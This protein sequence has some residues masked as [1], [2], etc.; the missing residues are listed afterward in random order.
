MDAL[1]AFVFFMFVAVLLVGGAQK[2]SLSYPIALILGGGVLGMI[3]GLAPVDIDPTILLV[4]VLPPIL[5]YAAYSIAFKEFIH[6]LKD[7]FYLAIVLVGI[8]TL[9]AG[10]LF[11]WLFPELPWSLAFTFGAIVSPP[12]AVAATAI[13]KRFAI[14]SRLK[15]ILEGESLINDASGL[16]IY[17]FAVVALM[18]GHFSLKEASFHAFY[19]GIVGITIGLI[20]G[21]LF[22]KLAAYLNPVLAVVN[23]FIIPY[24]TYCLADFLNASGVLA[25]VSCGLLGSRMLI[26]QLSP[27]TRVLAWAAWDIL[28][29]L[30]NC[31]IFIL[32]GLDFGQIVQKMPL[33]QILLFSG[34]GI[35]ITLAIILVRF[36]CIYAR[37]GIVHLLLLRN[38]ALLNENRVFLKHALISSWAGMRGIVSLTAALAI[39]LT[40]PDGT[41]VEGRDIVIFLTF[42]VI[43]L[44]LVIPGLTLA[45]LVKWLK[46]APTRILSKLVQA[47]KK[48]ADTAID[49]IQ[50]LHTIKQLN[51]EERELLNMYFHS[52]HKI[53]EFSSISEEH[54]VE[55]MRHHIVR[56]QR[57]SLVQM[58][59]KNEI[60]DDLMSR[61]EREL[62]LE[63][64]HLARGE[65]Q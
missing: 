45:G 28:I 29:I 38:P 52:R 35:L 46:I 18:T 44:T 6:Y 65:I 8:T 7:I 62:D 19:A 53:N 16:V 33:S 37:R 10:A 43:F 63:E 12:D 48:L 32:I 21:Y 15:T 64:S 23:S 55:Q 30:L 3:P 4:V 11:K 56:K 54:K 20:C 1:F 41:Y 13:L 61:L 24:M 14:S 9:V 34:Y 58:W 5:F 47:R 26:T 2:I 17:K 25:V 51:E 39:P 40:R 22:N 27:L 31:F 49:E 59:R 50:H 60:D 36:I 42:E 57:E